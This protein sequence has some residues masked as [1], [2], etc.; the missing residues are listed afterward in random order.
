MGRMPI[1]ICPI[2]DSVRQPRQT[3]G[4]SSPK[5]ANYARVPGYE[6]ASVLGEG[7]YKMSEE[8]LVVG[9]GTFAATHNN[10]M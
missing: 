9:M 6:C 8:L 5:V 7:S 1:E 4:L 2:I 3:G 10:I